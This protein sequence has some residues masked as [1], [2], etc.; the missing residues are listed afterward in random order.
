MAAEATAALRALVSKLQGIYD[1][2]AGEELQDR[3]GG[4]HGAAQAQFALEAAEKTLSE[5]ER[6]AQAF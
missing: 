2:A 3:G 4:E 6:R 5:W 1:D